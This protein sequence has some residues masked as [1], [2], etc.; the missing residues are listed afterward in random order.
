MSRTPNV[1]V[2]DLI[3]PLQGEF[4]FTLTDGITGNTQLI[5]DPVGP[6]DVAY[7]TE[8]RSLSKSNWVFTYPLLDLGDIRAT[9][10]IYNKI[11]TKV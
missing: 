3:E 10:A 1:F 2:W 6:T 5:T 4:D 7:F 8:I 9:K 11:G